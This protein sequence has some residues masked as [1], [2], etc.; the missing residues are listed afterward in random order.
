MSRKVVMFR[1]VLAG[2]IYQTVGNKYNIKIASTRQHV[3]DV[4]MFII[5]ES[6]IDFEYAKSRGAFDILEARGNQ[7]YWIKNLDSL[8]KERG[9][10]LT[11]SDILFNKIKKLADACAKEGMHHYEIRTALHKALRNY[12]D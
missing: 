1:D 7:R 8:I 11:E 12:K 5:R 3:N 10:L 2:G 6:K 4:F 9:A